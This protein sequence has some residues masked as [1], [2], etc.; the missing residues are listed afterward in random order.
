MLALSFSFD[1]IGYFAYIKVKCI[2]LRF[3]NF[4]GVRKFLIRVIL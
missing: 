3:E 1:S 2:Y 4:A